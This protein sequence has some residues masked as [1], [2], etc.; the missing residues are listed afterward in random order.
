MERYRKACWDACRGDDASLLLRVGR[1]KR[2]SWR[3]Q[4]CSGLRA[5]ALASTLV[6]P[7]R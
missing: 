7:T 5:V 3:A 2:G 4:R 1:E 6:P